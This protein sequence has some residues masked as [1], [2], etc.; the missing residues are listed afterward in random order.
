M[1]LLGVGLYFKEIFPE[2]DPRLQI[3][4][5]LRSF[6]LRNID[7]YVDKVLVSSLD[8]RQVADCSILARRM[9]L[10]RRDV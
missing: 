3:I 2:S 10:T 8:F 4:Q 1:P 5:S 7:E 6:F 9:N